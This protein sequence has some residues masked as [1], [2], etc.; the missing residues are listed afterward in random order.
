V[1]HEILWC[2]VENEWE[3]KWLDE[4]SFAVRASITRQSDESRADFSK[5]ATVLFDEGRPAMSQAT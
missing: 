3:A 2:W 5:R 4:E 1:N